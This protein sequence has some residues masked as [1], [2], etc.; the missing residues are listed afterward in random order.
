[1]L[2][3]GIILIWPFVLHQV[4]Y[5]LGAFEESLTYALGAGT[6]FDVNSTSEYVETTIAKCIDHYTKLR[7]QNAD[8]SEE[9]RKDIDSRLEGIVNRMFKRCFDDRKYKQVNRYT[10]VICQWRQ[11]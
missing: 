9:D 2:T 11:F 5:H 3:T 8:A 7:V 6:L 10:L 1:M 4:Y